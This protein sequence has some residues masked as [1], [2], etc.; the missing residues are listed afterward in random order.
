MA[1]DANRNPNPPSRAAAGSAAAV[2]NK[3]GDT[4]ILISPGPGPS[5]EYYYDGKPVATREEYMRLMEYKP[6]EPNSMFGTK[7]YS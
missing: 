2:L 7:S 1:D 6:K 5:G 4:V 3:H